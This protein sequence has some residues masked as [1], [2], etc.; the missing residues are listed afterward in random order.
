MYYQDNVDFLLDYDTLKL[1]ILLKQYKD[2][3]VFIV[4]KEATSVNLSSYYMFFRENF[5]LVSKGFK[6]TLYTPKNK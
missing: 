5:D 1:E 2:N 6:Y 4:V 3:K